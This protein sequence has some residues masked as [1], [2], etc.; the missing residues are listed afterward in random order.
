MSNAVVFYINSW[1]A[2]KLPEGLDP[3]DMGTVTV[4]RRGVIN[5]RLGWHS[6]VVWEGNQEWIGLVNG[7]RD[8]LLTLC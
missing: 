6:G 4:S 8:F 3:P 5:V 1:V 7:I 2:F